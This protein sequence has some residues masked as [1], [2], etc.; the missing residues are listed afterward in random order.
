MFMMRSK[1]VLMK[2]YL[3]TPRIRF[4]VFLRICKR[5]DVKNIVKLETV[6]LKTVKQYIVLLKKLYDVETTKF[7]APIEYP[8]PFLFLL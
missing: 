4:A 5:L 1:W 7:G 8:F 3:I 2:F 6:F